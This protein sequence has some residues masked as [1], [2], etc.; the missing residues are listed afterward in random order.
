MSRPSEPAA[1]VPLLKWGGPV[2]ALLGLIALALLL[3]AGLRAGN[4]LA[5]WLTQE[6]LA[7]VRVLP[8]I[9]LGLGFALA[10]R[11]A[12]LAGILLMA[13]GIATGFLVYRPLLEP[14]WLLPNAV[15]SRFFTAPCLNVAVGIVLVFG[16]RWR[17][18]MLPPFAFVA[19]LLL[20][21]GII[22]TDPSLNDPTYARFGVLTS[23]AII[24]AAAVC[25][26]VL[27]GRLLETGSRIVG[28]WLIAIGLLY[29]AAALSKRPASMSGSP[30]V[31]SNAPGSGRRLL[32]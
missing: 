1:A 28:S 31:S 32:Q 9:G 12:R 14:V 19:G 11:G 3:A 24:A 23:L 29:G 27:R 2:L 6:V 21:F 5:L 7:P 13:L 26:A 8:L 25:F 18:W 30:P 16:A 4:A 15:E 20:A 22:V 17:N 10:G